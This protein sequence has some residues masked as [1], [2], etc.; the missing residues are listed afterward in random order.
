MATLAELLVTLG[1]KD[2]GFEKGMDELPNKAEGAIDKTEGKFEGLGGKLAPIAKGAGI[3]AGAAVVA[4]VVVG[5]EQE[6]VTDKIAAS[7]DLSEE[8]S[9]TAGR[10]AG[11][12]YA[13][14]YGESFGQV[15]EAVGA[16]TG[17]LDLDPAGVQEVSRKALDLA[18][19]FDMDVTDAV[20]KAGI[21]METGLAKDTDHAMDLIAASMQEVAPGLRDELSEATTE[22]SK[23]FGDLGFTGEETFGLLSSA[24]DKFSLDKTGD[25]IKELSI[26]AGDGSTAT[27]EAF[28]AMGMDAGEMGDDILAG[29]DRAR[30]AFDTIVDGLLEMENPSERAQ[31]AVALFG[32]P[33]EDLSTAQIP[34][35]L[36]S[37]DNMGGG[38]QDVE[39]RADDMGDTL[40]D[41]AKTKI[42]GYKRS[43]EQ[44]LAKIV[45]LPGPMGEIGAAAGAM[46]SM[47][48]GVAGPAIAGFAA[49][50]GLSLSKFAGMGSKAFGAVKSGFGAM[51]KVVMANP[52][53]ALIVGTIAL[54]TL[55][56]ANWDKITAF[57]KKA[58][59]F[60]MDKTEGVRKWLVDKFRMAVDFI[61][62][63]FFNFTPLGIIISKFDK[64]KAAVTGV[65][66]W[67]KDKFQAAVDFVKNL[68]LNFTPLG[69]FI[70]HMD[71]I[72][73]AVTGV[74]DWVSEKIEDIV[75]FFRDMP[76]RIS[77]VVGGLF[78]GLRNAFR[79]AVNWVIDKWNNFSLEIQ[80]PSL[81]GG[82][83]IGI[84]TPN[85][86][87]L[88]EGTSFFEP[89]GG[90]SEGLAVLERGER[91]T[92]AGEGGLFD[93]A[94]F[95]LQGT[96]QSMVRDLSQQVGLEVRFA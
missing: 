24:D 81:L 21:L 39:G 7:L 75:G 10:I 72:K 64:I 11:E 68:F 90:A 17:T 92:P 31:T 50:G 58:W 71:S 2:A 23:F 82:G 47:V 63:L 80:L 27:V 87:R 4:G 78:D 67:I 6:A 83:T 96:P 44:A 51:S 34:E 88:H 1:V 19:T 20:T 85:I 62:N 95:N 12:L 84:D 69:L 61:K 25:A 15:S 16:V 36:G 42:A 86:P 49:S 28:E 48:S 76:G 40:N 41:N 94:T 22:Y 32:T 26:R 77:R 30:D 13:D 73:E 33:I 93:G 66:E 8:E 5:I 35:F 9:A 56:I 70:Q 74:K 45:E 57:L 43:I 91:V 18:S 29:G 59:D 37:L 14:A 54:V 46:G 65:W 52:W 60:I 53:I 89:P 55:I 79:D 3:A 38:L